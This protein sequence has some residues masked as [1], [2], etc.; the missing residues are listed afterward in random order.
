MWYLF[1]I[2]AVDD[3]NA[4]LSERT[5]CFKD[6]AI[7]ARKTEK[8]DL[9]GLDKTE[10]FHR[11]LSH[12]KTLEIIMQHQSVIPIK[13]GTV[14]NCLE[15]I[16]VILQRNLDLFR[17]ILKEMKGKIEFSLSISWDEKAQLKKICQEDKDISEI[18][19]E[20]INKGGLDALAK[21][22][23]A[24]ENKLR[25][26]K[27]Q[28]TAGILKE[29]NH[30]IIARID[31]KIPEEKIIANISFLIPQ[32]REEKFLE[33]I[34]HV[35]EKF[36]G[37]IDFKCISPLPPHSF[38]TV[39]IQKLSSQ[40]LSEAFEFFKI[41]EETTL[42][43]LKNKNRELIR[44]YHPDTKQENEEDDLLRVHETFNLLKNFFIAKDDK[45]FVNLDKERC[46]FTTISSKEG[47]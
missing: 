44:C 43:E 42:E 33:C 46:F 6:I 23:K 21:F 20:V 2:V 36:G 3:R 1:G 9:N 28:I 11:L 29:L 32:D 39:H 38:C 22:G 18:K 45:P 12:Q 47:A 13:F 5:V 27:T 41:R 37:E 30:L 24:L 31:H 15:E 34:G 17:R 26:R 7:I 14:V 35:D 19:T 10:I 16:Q 8:W 40:K 25:E 4:M